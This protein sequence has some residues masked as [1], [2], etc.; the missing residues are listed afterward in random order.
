MKGIIKGLFI[1]EP[2]ISLILNGEKI[3]EIRGSKTNIRGRI[4]LIASKSGEVKGY[5]DL[6]DCLELDGNMF[7]QNK[8]KHNIPKERYSSENLPYKKTY[9]W[10]LSNPKKLEKGLV[11]KQKK[12]CVIWINLEEDE[13]IKKSKF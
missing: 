13:I 5:V 2:W 1:K 3:W 10:V 4:A 6:I 12:G 9:A 8:S 11:F 7:D